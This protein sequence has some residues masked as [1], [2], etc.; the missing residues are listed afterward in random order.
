MINSFWP[1]SKNK[2]VFALLIILLS[3][4]LK[5]NS[6]QTRVWIPS[7]KIWISILQ[8]WRNYTRLIHTLKPINWVLFLKSC[9]GLMSLNTTPRKGFP[10]SEAYSDAPH[11]NYSQVPCTIA[12]RNSRK[13]RLSPKKIWTLMFKHSWTKKMPKR[14]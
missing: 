8:K 7:L 1:G 10:G 13:I 3:S 5:F 4:Q 9:L 12:H 11:E 6:Y 14:N 2:N